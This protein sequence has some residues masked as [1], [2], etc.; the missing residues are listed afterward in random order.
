MRIGSVSRN[1]A[2]LAMTPTQSENSKGMRALTIDELRALLDVATDGRLII[3]DLCGRNGLRPAEARAVRWVDVDLD[4]GELTISGQM[5]RQNERTTPKTEEGRP[6]HPDRRAD[7]R[8]A[9]ALAS[10]PGRTPELSPAAPGSNR[11]WSPRL[12][13]APRST[14]T[15]S[16]DRYAL[17]CSKAGIEPPISP[18]ELRHTAISMQADAG[19]SSWEIADWAGTS[20]AMISEVYRH[21]LHRVANLRTIAL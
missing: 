21:R 12:P 16:P 14:A 17:Y 11:T 10:R 3:I 20:E 15:A 2:D 1:V 5:N 4:Q 9:Q 19:H 18:Y 6:H 8:A 7:H 13:S